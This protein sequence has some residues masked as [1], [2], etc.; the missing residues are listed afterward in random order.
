[1]TLCNVLVAAAAAARVLPG[2]AAS[3]RASRSRL[4]RGGP[5]CRPPGCKPLGRRPPRCK[6]PGRRPPHLS[7]AHHERLAAAAAATAAAA[8]ARAP[9][10]ARRP[11]SQSRVRLGLTARS[12]P[13]VSAQP[14]ECHP[15]GIW[16]GGR[17]R[18]QQQRRRGGDPHLQPASRPA[19]PEG[20]GDRGLRLQRAAHRLP[21]AASLQVGK[22]VEEDPQV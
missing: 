1:M 5:R 17:G 14:R 3:C 15:A 4:G 2:S 12:R 11:R 16:Y 10:R 21:A 18:L 8:A 19:H 13:P 9:G 7:T 6:P 20:D 22:E